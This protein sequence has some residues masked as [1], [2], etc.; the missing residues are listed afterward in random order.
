MIIID[1]GNYSGIYPYLQYLRDWGVTTIRF[2][3]LDPHSCEGSNI[4]DSQ[5]WCNSFIYTSIE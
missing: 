2:L 4:I 5:C 3:T 1:S